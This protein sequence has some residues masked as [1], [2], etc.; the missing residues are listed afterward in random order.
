MN[1]EWLFR[2]GAIAATG[3][4][5]TAC[6]GNSDR[7]RADGGGG[8]AAP[9]DV[10]LRAS[11]G[12]IV[13]ATCE[14]A[15]LNNPTNVLDTCLT[16]NNG[17]CSFTIPGD[18]GPI[19]SSCTGGRYFEE[20]LGAEVEVAEGQ[21]F[22]S[23]APSNRDRVA[24]TPFT[25]LIAERLV[26]SGVEQLLDADVEAVNNDVSSFFG[27]ADALNPPQPIRN[28]D[29]LSTLSGEEGA[30]AAALAGFSSVAGGDSQTLLNSLRDDIADGTINQINQ[31][32][33]DQATRSAAEGTEAE[34]DVEDNQAQPLRNNG[35]ISA[36]TGA[37]GGTG[38]GS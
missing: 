2:F 25:D 21:V 10:T 4:F 1:K 8:G 29:D 28:S 16:D 6:D 22:R 34:D 7:V 5:L 33:F 30:Y 17:D 36:P 38:G 27:V 14:I 18:T 26:N 19:L 12:A 32:D 15:P 23:A 11:K 37:T 9:R 13:G 35:D 31:N 24:V 20:A 3:I